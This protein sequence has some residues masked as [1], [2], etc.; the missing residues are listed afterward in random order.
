MSPNQFDTLPPSDQPETSFLYWRWEWDN[1][2]H[3]MITSVELMRR[4][5]LQEGL[6]VADKAIRSFW[7][8]LPNTL[9]SP[10]LTSDH[11]STIPLHPLSENLQLQ[12]VRLALHYS[13]GLLQLHRTAF[14]R[15]LKENAD[16]PVDSAY[17][18]SVHV[19]VNEAARYILALVEHLYAKNK[20]NT[21]HMVSP[22]PVIKSKPYTSSRS[23]RWISS[24]RLYRKLLWSFGHPVADSP[25][26]VITNCCAV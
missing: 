25:M 1:V 24:A 26:I 10:L 16:E 13:T 11:N 23:S 9:Q 4:S 21:R 8:R 20:V 7:R 2:L 18:F 6:E 5:Q 12:Q 14:G 22:S 19:V 15:A 17:G 3:D